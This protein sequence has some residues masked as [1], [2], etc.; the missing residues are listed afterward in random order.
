MTALS[1]IR[2]R[3]FRICSS[4]VLDRMLKNISLLAKPAKLSTSLNASAMGLIFYFLF[5]FF[6]SFF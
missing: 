3:H 5:F 2:R 6:F 1:L 4:Q